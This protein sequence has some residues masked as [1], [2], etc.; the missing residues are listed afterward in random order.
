MNLQEIGLSLSQIRS[1]EK[2]K[3]T[4][5]EAFLRKPPLHYYDFST[6]LPLNPENEKTR[7]M[8]DKHRPFSVTGICT[9]M[10]T[11]ISGHAKMVT[12]QIE[13]ENTKKEIPPVPGTILR[14][15]I[16]GYDQFRQNFL[17]E[18][19]D[20]PHRLDIRVPADIPAYYDGEKKSVNE[21]CRKKIKYLN[22][23]DE[24]SA[25][26]FIAIKTGGTDEWSRASLK[27]LTTDTMLSFLSVY[28]PTWDEQVSALRWYGRGLRLDLA[29]KKTLLDNDSCIRKLL[30]GKRTLIGGFIEYN[31]QMGF[32]VLNPPAVST[33]P[34]K[35]QTYMVQYSSVKGITPE[36]YKKMVQTGLRAVSKLDFI[37][38]DVCGRLQVPSFHESMEMM[39][40]PQSYRQIKKAQERADAEDLLYLALK[41]QLSNNS[42][43]GK[44]GIK[45]NDFS[46][47]RRY[48]ESLP[49]DL[50]RDQKNAVNTIYRQLAKGERV[51]A[52]VQ[53]D[54]GTGKTAVAFCLLLIAVGSGYQAALAAPYT[55]LAAQHYRDMQEIADSL[56]ITVAFLT[57]DVKGREKKKTLEQIRSGEAKIV[58]GT[59]SIFSK[60]VEYQNLALIIEDEEH[61]FGVV[62]RES[63]E[64]KALEGYHQVT[65]SATPIPKSLS[66]AMY[67]DSVD[68]ISILEK[69]ANRIPVQT[70]VCRKDDTALEFMEKQIR[71][72]HQCY[73]VCPSI[74]RTESGENPVASIEEKEAVYRNFLEPLGF[75]LAV[76]TGKLKAAE[77]KQIMEDFTEGKIDVLMATTVI[78]VGINVP[79]ATVITITG[80]DR[81]G[82]STLHQLRGRV[83]R[84]NAKSYCILQTDNPNEKLDFL[85]TTTDGFEIANKDLELRGPGSLFGE[86]QSGDNY[87]VS[88]MMA[89]PDLFERVKPIAKNLCQSGT[90]K[91]I[92][93]RYE[94]IFLPEEER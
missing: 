53:G 47:M 86:R 56:G 5:V 75:S 68:V 15:N 60:D 69:P 51:N 21:P 89:H 77:K 55:T 25:R 87:Y 40:F 83:G 43:K 70:A 88:L 78:E 19:P 79:N 62:H 48:T 65:M 30:L 49:Y 61:K 80:A 46:L 9:G 12:L 71:E 16:L 20:S 72:G 34:E 39:H 58:I 42:R 74:D 66:S 2:K 1:L 10:R 18:H 73:V 35:F 82:F 33:D 13:D 14:V 31:E 7:E 11:G 6:A 93:R 3:I 92:V 24:Y 44:P 41:L 64:S 45:L 26:D 4:S 22:E 57:S 17:E 28:L 59:H 38:P 36:R 94:E 54:V 23:L 67:D 27:S 8:L 85:C 37:P 50:T 52:L 84:G 32:S 91:D 29:V 90:G 76:V 81:F 63:F